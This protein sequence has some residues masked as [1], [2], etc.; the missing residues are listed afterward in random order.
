[1][2]VSEAVASRRSVRAF[3]D[4]PVD[5][6]LV[7][8]ILDRARMAPSGCNFQPWRGTVLSG[9]KLREV[10]DAMAAS[11]P[12]D[13]IEYSWSEPEKSEIHLRRL[14]ELGAQFYGAMEIERADKEGRA[15]FARQNIY[16]F[17]APV[18]LMVHFERLMGPPQWSDVGMWLQTIMLLCREE[19]LDTCPQEWMALYARLI[20][21]HIGVSDE[22]QILFCGIAIGYGDHSVPLNRF[23]RTRV[24]L[25]E[26]V[27]FLSE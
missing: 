3:L 8:S 2:N 17:G 16:S 7:R 9:A 22:E 10:Q 18:V 25:D 19:G 12:Q 21:Q 27:R 14:Q 24:P 15:D 23:E 5:L 26:Q 13:P 1:M 4:K 20:K 11:E 6:D